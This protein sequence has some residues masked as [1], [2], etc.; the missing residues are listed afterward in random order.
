MASHILNVFV[1]IRKKE[2][3]DRYQGPSSKFHLPKKEEEKK[4][5]IKLMSSFMGSV[6]NSA[7][8]IGTSLQH[9]TFLRLPDAFVCTF[10]NLS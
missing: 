5:V 6:T 3:Y 2:R 7:F 10:V 8:G 9:R 1:Q 4:R